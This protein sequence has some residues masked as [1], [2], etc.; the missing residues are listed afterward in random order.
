MRCLLVVTTVVL[1]LSATTAAEFELGR[2]HRRSATTPNIIL[3]VASDLG[4]GDLG[5]YG[6]TKIETPNLDRLAAEGMRF[7]DAYAGGASSAASRRA[8]MTGR[9]SA[10]PILN[11][12]SGIPLPETT[13]TL[14]RV[15]RAA[16]YTNC[17]TGVW[18]LGTAGSS[19]TP[20]RQGFDEWFGAFDEQ[21]GRDYYPA[22]LSRNDEPEP[23][24]LAGNMQGK[25]SDYVPDWFARVGGNFIRISQYD[26]FFL[27]LATTL[28]QANL[29]RVTDGMEVPSLGGYRQLPWPYPERA[30][31]A[32]ISRLDAHV[33]QLMAAVIQYHLE[34]NTVMI[35]TSAT[36]AHH[37]GGV[38]PR[39]FKSS[40]PFR[41]GRG[42]LYEGGLRVPFI[43]RWP[44][45]I[46]PGTT[47]GL[48][49]TFSDLLPTVAEL[50]GVNPPRETDGI[51]FAP[52]LQGR[53]RTITRDFLSW[54]SNEGGP[55]EAVRTGPWKAIRTEAGN[56]LALYDLR[57]DPSE[58][59]DV[60]SR[61]PDVLEKVE[62]HLREVR[63]R[64]KALKA[65]EAK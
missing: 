45:H 61:H 1:G 4:I 9:N 23:F 6:Q 53:P 37:D 50:V 21:S 42:E 58:S 49:I 28:P 47:N 12:E 41:G 20:N 27:Y 2:G 56:P 35:F 7:T 29:E 60:A 43:V 36:T 48:P 32:M 34:T 46:R 39:F 38:D 59:N 15:C 18:G 57:E 55:K 54:V 22:A 31:A 51:S 13:I 5:C 11:G 8:L 65:K 52:T 40:G 14:A 19:G 10:Y 33:G 24:L 30:K 16:G 63:E 64:A 3:I 44:G 26:P 17:A 62:A 25:R